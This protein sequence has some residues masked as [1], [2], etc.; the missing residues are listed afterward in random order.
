MRAKKK[1]NETPMRALTAMR[2]VTAMRA[3]KKPNETA[4]R[5]KKKTNERAKKKTN[6]TA[7]KAMREL[8]CRCGYQRAACGACG[9]GYAQL[10]ASASTNATASV[11]NAMKAK[12][13]NTKKRKKKPWK[14]VYVKC[15]G[16]LQAL[17]VARNAIQAGIFCCYQGKFMKFQLSPSKNKGGRWIHMKP[18]AWMNAIEHMQPLK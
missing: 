4:M 13:K 12:K 5:A 7:M 15:G 8:T 2:P 1:T 17:I 11:M 9:Q 14:H 16:G 6:E 10:A 18:A 3:K